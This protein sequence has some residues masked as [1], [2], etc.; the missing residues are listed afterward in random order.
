M[1]K[2]SIIRIMAIMN[3]SSTLIK[4]VDYTHESFDN[5]FTLLPR[6]E[7]KVM[8]FDTNPNQPSYP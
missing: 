3:Q 4:H 8:L 2:N 7:V 6:D 5:N 1:A